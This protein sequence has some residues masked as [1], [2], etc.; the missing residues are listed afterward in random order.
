[1]ELKFSDKI[2]TDICPKYWLFRNFWFS[3]YYKK[4]TELNFGVG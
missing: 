4:Q 1:M 2:T 3:M